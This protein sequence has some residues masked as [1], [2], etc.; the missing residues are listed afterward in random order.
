MQTQI[1]Y[2]EVFKKYLKMENM[3]FQ[4]T[5]DNY[6]YCDCSIEF[7]IQMLDALGIKYMIQNDWIETISHKGDNPLR[8]YQN[9]NKVWLWAIVQDE[10]K[11]NRDFVGSYFLTDSETNAKLFET[12]PN[13]DELLKKYLT[14]LLDNL[15]QTTDIAHLKR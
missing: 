8:F 9:D 7:D 4:K 14:P 6:Q 2:E 3:Q 15:V 13:I 10:F 12:Y 1:N 11:E 5:D